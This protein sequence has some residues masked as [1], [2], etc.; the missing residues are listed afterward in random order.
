MLCHGQALPR[1]AFVHDTVFSGKTVC[2]PLN[3]G[4]ASSEKTFTEA[5]VKKAALHKLGLPELPEARLFCEGKQ[6]RESLRECLLSDT[7]KA[8]SLTLAVATLVG[9]TKKKAKKDE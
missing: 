6:V 8:L 3:S 5:E 9:G 1:V 2:V 7:S 4:K